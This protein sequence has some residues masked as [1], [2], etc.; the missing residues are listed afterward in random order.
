MREM[1]AC[2]IATERGDWNRAVA[3]HTRLGPELATA[4][5]QRAEAED[6]AARHAWIAGRATDWERA[7]Y[8][9]AGARALAGLEHDDRGRRPFRTLA[10]AKDTAASLRPPAAPSQKRS[11][12][13]KKGSLGGYSTPLAAPLAKCSVS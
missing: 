10:E 8:S 2:G 12:P 3:E 1:E 11:N 6:A 7:G 4:G 5:R 13:L 9:P